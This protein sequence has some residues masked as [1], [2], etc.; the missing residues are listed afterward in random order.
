MGRMKA[1]IPEVICEESHDLLRSV[2]DVK[3]GGKGRKYTEEELMEEVED[4]DAV[5]TTSRHHFTKKVIESAKRLRIIAKYGARPD[6][7]DIEAATKKGIAVTWT[8]N[9]NDDSVAEH[10]I[11]FMLALIKKLPFMMEHLRKGGWRSRTKTV[12]NELLGKTVGIIGLGAIGSKVADKLKSFDVK[13]LAYDPYVSEEQA[14][15]VGA[16]MVNLDTLLAES[17]IVTV[18]A[19]LTESTRGLIGE[20]ELKRMKK[21]AF[22]INTSR[23][24]LVEENA[25]Y[26]ALTSRWISGA[27]LDVFSRE[28]PSMDNPLLKLDNVIVSPHIAA[29][30]EESL[31]RQAVMAT[32]EVVEFLKGKRPK[33]VLNPDVLARLT[34][35]Y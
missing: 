35:R 27:A 20:E 32:E 22:L 6:N 2:A 23:G 26:K 13:A 9:T 34:D 12:T 25:L 16:E 30:T 28:P 1:F 11:S 8:P 21:T 4:V 19:T 5:L 3:L 29:W 14:K 17:D 18:H 24:P 10:A 33:H 7:I 31:K 15:E